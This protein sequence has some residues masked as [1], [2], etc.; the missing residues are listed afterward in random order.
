LGAASRARIL[1]FD[2]DQFLGGTS[3]RALRKGE[4]DGLVAVKLDR[5]SRSTRDV[6]D[7]VAQAEREDW[8][9]HSIEE[10]LDTSSAHGRFVVTVLA[11]LAELERGQTAERTRDALA[12]MRRRGRRV[13]GRPPFGFRFEGD[14]LEA[15]PEEQEILGRM[16]RL[17]SRGNGARRIAAK[18][19]RDGTLNPRTGRPWNYGTVAAI[20]RTATRREG[21]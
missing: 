13:S 7:L 2:P 14:G 8:A 15:V 9:L 3:L 5:M 1:T 16:M 18:L 19:N 12:E 20:L 4:A 21:E 11:A 10:K 6:L 17:R